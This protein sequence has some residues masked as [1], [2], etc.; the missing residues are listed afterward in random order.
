MCI[1][2]DFLVNMCKTVSDPIP[3]AN[4]LLKIEMV[5]RSRNLHNY[6]IQ[7]TYD[8]VELNKPR[9][10][11]S[12]DILLALDSGDRKVVGL[13]GHSIGVQ[14]MGQQLSGIPLQVLIGYHQLWG[15]WFWGIRLQVYQ[16][17]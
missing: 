2:M 8:K 7:L 5:E 9:N 13:L 4:K 17:S 6:V 15:R 10:Y 11:N 16:N 1:S 14:P 3:Q 12:L